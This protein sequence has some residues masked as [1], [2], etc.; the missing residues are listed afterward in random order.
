MQK[1]GSV[2][3]VTAFKLNKIFLN[4]HL[5][6]SGGYSDYIENLYDC[7]LLVID[8]LGTENIYKNVTCEY[9]LSL[10]S[11]RITNNRHTL[12]TTNLGAEHL[13]ARYDDR[14][15]SRLLDKNKTYTICF[16]GEDLR[17]I[18]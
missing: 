17:Q 7:D 2:I 12:I 5:D 3:F 14:F 16:D 6:F 15:Y 10:I 8:D 18:K 11:E 1:G 9:F 4:Y 13:R